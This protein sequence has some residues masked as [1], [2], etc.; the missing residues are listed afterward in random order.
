MALLTALVDKP[1][2]NVS[3]GLFQEMTSFICERLLPNIPVVQQTGKVGK[4]GTSHLRV[5]ANSMGGRG[6]APRVELVAPDVSTTYT[7]ED[8]GLE[9]VLSPNDYRNYELP[10][11]AERDAVMANTYAN[12]VAKEYAL[13][14]AMGS[15]AGTLT[16]NTTLTGTS[17]FS[18]LVNSDP[19]AQILAARQA[20]RTN[21]GM[22]PNKAW[23]EANV[24]ETLRVHPQL[25]DR[26]GFK[27]NQSGQLS[28]ANVAMALNVK[29]LLVAESVYDSS[30]QGQTASMA[31]IW[32][33]TLYFGVL[34]DAAAIMQKSLGYYLYYGNQ[35]KRSVYKQPVVNPPNAVSIIVKDDY[36]MLLSDVLCGYAIYGAIA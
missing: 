27:F 24:Y 19:V 13:S 2:T 10:F 17:Q 4:Y 16:Q 28:Q 14:Y 5:H 12:L 34:P 9:I 29:E 3:N 8:H 1:L 7:V 20:V 21:C 6:E 36:D 23:C 30:S 32:S 11:D 18:D 26:L 35:G 25:W 22:F 33:K 31:P 15:T